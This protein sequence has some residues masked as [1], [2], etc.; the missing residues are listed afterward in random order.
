MDFFYE[1]VD[2]VCG[3]RIIFLVHSTMCI[4]YV[5]YMQIFLI[6]TTN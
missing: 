1:K 6:E 3:S 5:K 2:I 4:P